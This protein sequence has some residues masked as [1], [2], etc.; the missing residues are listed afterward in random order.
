M[1]EPQRL[2]HQKAILQEKRA[3]VYRQII[4][5]TW[6]AVYAALIGAVVF[7]V[8]ISLFAIPS[9]E[10][11]EN[12]T[13][14]L[15]S[16]VLG[17]NGEVLDRYFIENRVPVG[18]SD[19][20][21]H[22]VHALVST[23][24][25]RY[26]KHCG[27]DQRA[28]LR[29]FVRTILLSDQSAGGGSTITQQL[30]KMLYSDR[31]F[32]GMNKVQ[33]MFALFYR[34]FREWITAV[35]LERSYTKEEIIA[36][37]LN[38]VDF[39][40]DAQ[41]IKAAAEVYFGK[42]QKNLNIQESATLIG[43][44]QNP[45]RYNPVRFPERC[46]RRRRVV[47]YQ[48]KQ[49]K[50]LTEAQYDSLKVLPLDMSRFKRV[51]FSDGIAP[52]FCSE[53]KKDLSTI[54]NRPECRKNDGSKYDIYKD[55]LRIYTSIDPVYQAHAEA[56]MAAHMKKMQARFFEVWRGLDPWTY[57]S[58]STTD[59]E[60][61]YRRQ[62]LQMHL[63]E[64]ERFQ[65]TWNKYFDDLSNKIQENYQYE[66]RPFDI[67]RML[68]EEK[69]KGALD[70]MVRESIVAPA[71]STVYRR[72]MSNGDLWREI[73]RQW[74]ALD[75]DVRKQFNTKIRMKVFT[76]D[77]PG[78][79]KDTLM[80]PM[81]S[82]KY[83]RMFLQ[84]GMMAMDPVT[85]EVKAWVGGIHFRHFK[86]DHVRSQRQ[87]GSTF[88]PFV[89][90]TAIAQQGISPCYKVYD[91]AVTIPPRYQNFTNSAPWTP[92][93]STGSYSGRLLTLREAL[94]GSV[95]SVS[96]FIMK[97]LGDTEPVRGLLNNM[98][99]DSAARHPNGDYR[100]PKQPAICLGAADLTVLEMTGAYNTFANNGV[101]AMPL[102]I[103]KIEDKNGRVIYQSMPEEKV[104]LPANANYVM[105]DMLRYNV[106]GAPGIRDLQSDTGG[107]TGTTND[108]SDAWFMGVTPRLVVG[109]WVGGEDRWIRFLSIADGQGSRLSR[110]IFADFIK[111]LEND[112]KS[113]YDAQARFTRPPGELGIEINCAAYDS[114]GPAIRD[115]EVEFAPDPFSD[116]M[117]TS[118]EGG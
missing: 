80:T 84:T 78:M 64:S 18:F 8:G 103:R 89:Y 95:N 35:K 81:D 20:S 73:K 69:Q 33:K 72:L 51:T 39:I 36:M 97:Q 1:S 60:L 44:L 21:P 42:S 100:I 86:F 53:M 91:Q 68:E 12:P 34:K 56:A 17:A 32:A 55:G 25:E 29:V 90:S 4:R 63:Y 66:L 96:A 54:L 75:G 45:S 46:I 27:V 105:L 77:T 62:T 61:A 83:H 113:G 76:W 93:N 48:M 67:T 40:N 65:A 23:E 9:F 37:Y 22:I 26:Y 5:W 110:P 109:T 106:K 30:A 28:I 47:L 82:I 6:I 101:Y 107:K 50:H 52:Y 87:V 115:E 11:L 24:D 41:G 7:F 14:A 94:K 116:E 16:E 38:Q 114:I 57:K 31:N 98:G 10:E 108:Y 15:A 43:M 112:P 58:R 70:R 19:L 85:A 111:R 49:N 88:K 2:I 71:Q 117:P 99:I 92:K 104:A 118:G 102:Y 74:M 13:S 3:P 79:E 59:E